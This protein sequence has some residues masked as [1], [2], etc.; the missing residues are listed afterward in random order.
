MPSYI[1]YRFTE[2]N[3]VNKFDFTKI[4]SSRK[5][6]YTKV[7]SLFPGLFSYTSDH[8]KYVVMNK[9]MIMNN[10]FVRVSTE[11]E[12]CFKLALHYVNGLR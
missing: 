3:F 2:I 9:R 11:E 6:Y 5:E 4:P 1:I 8:K 10:E 7:N 12:E